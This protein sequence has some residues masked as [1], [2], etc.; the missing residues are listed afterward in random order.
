MNKYILVDNCEESYNA[1]FKAV[2]DIKKI[3]LNKGFKTIGLRIKR[4]NIFGVK[5]IKYFKSVIGDV[6]KINK[7][8][9]KGST[10]VI[11]LPVR[12]PHY[13]LIIYIQILKKRNCK[14]IGFIHDVESLRYKLNYIEAKIEIEIFKQLDQIVVHNEKMK[15]YFMEIGFKEEQLHCIEI[16]DY[17]AEGKIENRSIEKANTIVIAG[18][19]LPEKAGYIYKM[20]DIFNPIKVKLY[21]T[22]YREQHRLDVIYC[23]KFPSNEIPNILSQE[24]NLFGLVWD[25]DSIDE[26]SGLI[27]KYQMYNNP[28]KLSLYL[29]S[30]LPVIVWNKSASSSF[31]KE[32]KVGIC[33]N[34]LREIKDRISNMSKSEKEELCNNAAEIGSKLRR[35]YYTEKVLNDI[36]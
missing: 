11:Q 2:D 3:L 35:G 34:S 23:G 26:C 29:A 4:N 17:L 28:H 1:S 9:E 30:G 7:I 31:V 27:G 21:G 18:N 25:G 16:F 19:L 8:V 14:I 22:N 13:L 36:L 20:A 5:Y 10:I 24:D 12:F 32:N 15:R 33:V 6:K